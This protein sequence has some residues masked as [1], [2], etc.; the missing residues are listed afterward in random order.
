MNQT[1][2]ANRT[3]KTKSQPKAP[4][5]DIPGLKT[6]QQEDEG[7]IKETK[8]GVKR[9]VI[10]MKEVDPT[11]KST[12]ENDFPEPILKGQNAG[13]GSYKANLTLE[14]ID[15]QVRAPEDVENPIPNPKVLPRPTN[16]PKQKKVVPPQSS[17][18]PGSPINTDGFKINIT[19]S[20]PNP[21]ENEPPT[22]KREVKELKKLDP[23][24]KEEAPKPNN[25]TADAPLQETSSN[26]TSEEAA[27]P[28]GQKPSPSQAKPVKPVA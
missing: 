17:E 26:D 14:R 11:V 3:K 28:E 25:V 22:I 16:L 1:V 20:P 5:L 4:K 2:S 13:N 21:P 8:N 24:H 12:E 19:V 9:E 7:T 15:P 10:K 18:E 23:N 27:P 6:K